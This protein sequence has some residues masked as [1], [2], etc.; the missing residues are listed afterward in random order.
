MRFLPAIH[1]NNRIRQFAIADLHAIQLLELVG[2][3]NPQQRREAGVQFLCECPAILL[4]SVHQLLQSGSE[5]DDAVKWTE[6]EFESQLTLVLFDNAPQLIRDNASHLSSVERVDVDI[7]CRVAFFFDLIRDRE[8]SLG[9]RVLNRLRVMELDCGPDLDRKEL[10][11]ASPAGQD[12]TS[13]RLSERLNRRLPFPLDSE[14]TFDR[15]QATQFAESDLFADLVTRWRFEIPSFR[16]GCSQWEERLQRLE[17][18]ERQFQL[19]LETEKLASMR[20][21]AYGA[22]HEVNNPL[23]NISTRAQALL[24]DETDAKRRQRLATIDAQAFRAHDMIS[25]LMTFARPPKPVFKRCQISPIAERVLGRLQELAG[26]QNSQLIQ[27]VDS[28]LYI[29]ADADQ[30]EEVLY[31]MVQNSLESLRNGGHVK[32]RSGASDDGWARIEVID[33]GPGMDANVR[34]HLFDPFFSG[35]EAGR[36]LGFGLSKAHRLIEL[37]RGR[38][39]VKDGDLGAHFEICLPLKQPTESKKNMERTA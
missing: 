30:I 5:L 35:R 1:L 3:A 29:E 27:E 13:E 24:R 28:G 21:L 10:T 18:L 31:A 36:G 17:L 9:H 34:R 37:H 33:D 38:I 25:N 23:A 39:F 16:D 22:S 7:F 4:W 6:L 20:Q 15:F 14:S 11:V 19:E 26:F 32:I 2:V 8:L 12:A